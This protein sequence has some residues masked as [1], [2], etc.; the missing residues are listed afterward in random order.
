LI[1]KVIVSDLS[2]K[3]NKKTILKNFSLELDSGSLVLLRGSTG[4]GKTTLLRILSGLIPEFYRGF[5][6][7]G[8]VKVFEHPPIQALR[9]ALITYVPQDPYSYF[10]GSTPREELSLFGLHINQSS[11]IDNKLLDKSLHKLSDGQLYLFL[12]KLAYLQ[13]AKLLLLDEPTSH[14]DESTYNYVMGLMKN[15]AEANDSIVI[16]V[17]HR[18][19]A[20]KYADYVVKLDNVQDNCYED[21]PL[22]R[23]K[24]GDT[25]LVLENYSCFH[26]GQRT[27]NPI[28][29]E[30]KRGEAVAIYGA[31]GSGKTTLMWG[32]ACS[33][34]C[35]GTRRL[36]GKVFIIPQTPIY[37]FDNVPVAEIL[38]KFNKRKE[39]IKYVAERFGLDENLMS[40]NLSI[41]K[42]RLLSLAL[43]YLSNKEVVLIDEPTIGLDCNSK[44]SLLETIQKLI[45]EGISIIITTHDMKFALN[46]ER[47]YI[48]N[49]G[50]LVEM[51]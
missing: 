26:D 30:V 24:Q 5:Q 42:A 29:L 17:D 20:A 13:K 6:V 50:T 1:K 21:L 44:K 35:K 43:A 12:V 25:A 49:K 2:V 34:N 4:S 47:R 40:Y 15:Y 41:G 14:L 51:Q 48:L 27:I 22:V 3:I 10:I 28:S 39:N 16:I 31:N 32:I 18:D 11:I 46:F 36:S 8:E 38:Q 19:D 45:D 7:S 9:K 33:I 37:W 23:N